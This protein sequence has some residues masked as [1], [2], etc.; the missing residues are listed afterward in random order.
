MSKPTKYERKQ[1]PKR[2]QL[3]WAC[4]KFREILERIDN[5]CMAADGYVTG[6]LEA[7]NADELRILYK[8]AGKIIDAGGRSR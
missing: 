1:T 6:T 4:R 2:E 7:A 8:L 3:L 5:R